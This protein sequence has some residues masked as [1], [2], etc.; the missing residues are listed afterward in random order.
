MKYTQR[1]QNAESL[2]KLEVGKVFI[3]KIMAL[4][5]ERNVLHVDKVWEYQHRARDCIRLYDTDASRRDIEGALTDKE[6]EFQRNFFC[7]HRNIME[8]E[9]NLF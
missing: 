2:I 7:T 3:S 6:I 8:I 4:C 5:V 9:R 1:S